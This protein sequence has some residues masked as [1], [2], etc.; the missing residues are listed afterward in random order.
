MPH[1]R[2]V[3]A[4]IAAFALLLPTAAAAAQ[5]G[6]TRPRPRAR[7]VGTLEESD[8]AHAMNRRGDVPFRTGQG[9]AGVWNAVTG[10]RRA[11]ADVPHALPTDIADDGRVVGVRSGQG[12]VLW[13]ADGTVT[14]PGLPEG[15]T[16]ADT[17]RLG[18]DGTLLVAA[19]H[20]FISW[21]GGHP[22]VATSYYRWRPETGF[23]HL[24][25]PNDGSYA[26]ALNDKGIVVGWRDD[27]GTA[28][29]PDGTEV[30][31]SGSAPGTTRT[32]LHDINNAGVAV[33]GQI[34][35]DGVS[36]AVRWGA[37]D[38]PRQL[39]DEGLGGQALDINARGWITG[40]VRVTADTVATSLPAVWD[41]HGAPHRLDSMLDL[42]EGTV[43]SIDDIND[44][45][46]LLLR[47]YDTA[48]G[49]MSTLVV[50]LR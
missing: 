42:P 41:P 45:N 38:A 28:W 19:S 40:T 1:R 2:H 9:G 43:R 31:Y 48:A 34:R 47:V 30:R 5:D 3:A 12:V 14:T 4:V 24:S 29:R 13:G 18:E 21:P 26:S 7:V 44:H 8:V 10:E 20:Q 11:L 33:G 27:T 15:E 35:P 16:S 23:Q 37:P 32:W 25:G 6:P 49:R 39:A 46:Q 17:A 50:Q 22:R 36:A